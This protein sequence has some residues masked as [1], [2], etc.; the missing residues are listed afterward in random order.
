MKFLFKELMRESTSKSTWTTHGPSDS[1]TAATYVACA[2]WAGAAPLGT[3]RR[4]IING[5]RRVPR[6]TSWPSSGP[7]PRP[8]PQRVYLHY[9]HNHY[10]RR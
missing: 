9:S 8:A 6:P 5:S 7:A 10:V 3:G 1:N 2:A 4:G